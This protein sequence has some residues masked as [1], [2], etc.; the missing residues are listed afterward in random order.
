MA[1]SREIADRTARGVAMTLPTPSGLKYALA[2][3]PTE[4]SRLARRR[5]TFRAAACQRLC[6]EA[7]R[8][9][10]ASRR[11]IRRRP[12]RGGSAD[13]PLTEKIR[14]ALLAGLLPPIDGRL[15]AGKAAGDRVCACCAL[16]IAEGEV[17]YEPRSAP[18]LHAHLGC[19]V[20]WRTESALLDTGGVTDISAPAH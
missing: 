20:A 16:S 5:A 9:V 19:F 14:G 3:T 6:F 4:Y 10:G 18:G 13:D 7:W 17:E 15:Y 11:L 8:H 2:V 1:R 12:L